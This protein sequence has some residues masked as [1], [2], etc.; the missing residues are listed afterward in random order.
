[1]KPHILFASQ[2]NTLAQSKQERCTN[3]RTGAQRI[4][5]RKDTQPEVVLE[6][7]KHQRYSVFLPASTLELC[8]VR[9]LA[10]V[11]TEEV[12]ADPLD[13]VRSQHLA[14]AQPVHP[15]HLEF[16]NTRTP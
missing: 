7:G 9:F 1:M 16:I 14:D 12:W 5:D 2:I 8:W 6:N 3:D 13:L 11:S 4:R 15:R 10:P